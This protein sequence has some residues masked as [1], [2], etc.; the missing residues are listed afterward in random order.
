MKMSHRGSH[1]H[2]HHHHHHQK[3]VFPYDHPVAGSPPY[4]HTFF[5]FSWVRRR[6]RRRRRRRKGVG[7]MLYFRE[8]MSQETSL[9]EGATPPPVDSSQAHPPCPC[10]LTWNRRP[11][12]P[13]Q[14]RP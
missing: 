4:D 10:R 5:D 7:K 9:V 13:T 14:K 3:S 2:H 6:R 1:H 8:K 11:V 12:L